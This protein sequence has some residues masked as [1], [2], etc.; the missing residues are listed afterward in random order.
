MIKDNDSDDIPPGEQESFEN[1]NIVILARYRDTD[2]IHYIAVE[3]PFTAGN[4]DTRRSRR[5]ANYIARFTGQPSRAV[6]VAVNMA[7]ETEATLTAISLPGLL[8]LPLIPE[9]VHQER[10]AGH[11]HQ[12]ICS[13]IT[14][15]NHPG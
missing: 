7:S 12:V 3:A 9:M 4:D 14:A 2:E 1:A 6:A 13:P 11:I 5:N 10:H 15:R 8:E